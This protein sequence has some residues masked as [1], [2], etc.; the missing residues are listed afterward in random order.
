LLK[1]YNIGV[2]VPTFNEELLIK[3]TIDGIPDY[4]RRI[5]IIDDGST[6]R[7]PILLNNE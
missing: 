5:Y 1:L 4:V 6:D 2:V 3:E 7:T